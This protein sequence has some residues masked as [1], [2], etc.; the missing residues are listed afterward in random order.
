MRNEKTYPTYTDPHGVVHAFKGVT[1][2]SRGKR[3]VAFISRN[4]RG[5]WNRKVNNGDLVP[6]G[7]WA[8]FGASVNV[9][10]MDNRLRWFERDGFRVRYCFIN[11]ADPLT[12]KEIE[13]LNKENH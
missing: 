4:D 1:E 2:G 6:L 9:D 13:T 3:L 12:L 8:Y 7:E 5:W 11:L 10:A